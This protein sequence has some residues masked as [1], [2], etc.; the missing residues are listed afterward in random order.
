MS[1]RDYYGGPWSKTE[2]GL[3]DTVSVTD[4]ARYLQEACQRGVWG[5]PGDYRLDDH[6]RARLTIANEHGISALLIADDTS[7]ICFCVWF[8]G[9]IQDFTDPEEGEEYAL[10]AVRC[11]LWLRAPNWP[12][13]PLGSREVRQ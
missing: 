8:E 10:A 3:P 5:W 7:G 2:P 13:L 11:A 1:R 6:R 4:A 12:G 9:P